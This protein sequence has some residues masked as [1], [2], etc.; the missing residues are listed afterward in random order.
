MRSYDHDIPRRRLHRSDNGMLLGVCAGIAEHLDLSR[1]GVRL[2]FVILQIWV[3]KYTWVAYLIAAILLP[4][5]H[6]Y[7]TSRRSYWYF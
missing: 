1:W 4:K 3:F 2:I 5:S 7:S 6:R